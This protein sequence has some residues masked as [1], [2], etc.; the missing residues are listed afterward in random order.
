[1]KIL[2]EFKDK[3]IDLV[4]TD[5]PYGILKG[6]PLGKGGGVAESID[7]PEIDWD[8]VSISKEQTTEII[9][10]SKNQIIFGGNHFSTFLPQSRGWMVWDKRK[11]GEPCDYAD[12]ELIW[13]SFDCVPRIF[14]LRWRGFIKDTESVQRVHPTQKPVKLVEWLVE[15]FSKEGDVVLDPFLGSRTTILACQNLKRSCIGIEISPEYVKI[16]EE[17]YKENKLFNPIKT[18]SEF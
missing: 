8:N 3:S 14:Y 1:M 17:R 4:L 13:T 2:P 15:N 11:M 5:P 18:L 6:A 10:V 7:Y 9:R 16:A 12:C